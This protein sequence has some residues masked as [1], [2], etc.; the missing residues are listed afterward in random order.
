MNFELVDMDSNPKAI[1]LASVLQKVNDR[2]FIFHIC[3]ACTPPHADNCRNCF[4]YGFTADAK[5][6]RAG[7]AG[8]D[9]RGEYIA[10]PVCGGTPWNEHLVE[11]GSQMAYLVTEKLPDYTDFV[12][13]LREG[14]TEW[15]LGYFNQHVDASLSD[16]QWQNPYSVGDSEGLSVDY[17]NDVIKWRDLEPPKESE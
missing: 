10:C 1:D 2:M 11:K 9:W 5:L 4:G 7:D 3:R 8:E 17:Y 12:W 15:E 6:I 16:A 13:I 14:K